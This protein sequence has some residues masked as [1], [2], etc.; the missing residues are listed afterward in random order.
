MP[1]IKKNCYFKKCEKPAHAHGLCAAHAQ[2]IR[3]G[4]TLRPLRDFTLYPE[5]FCSKCEKPFYAKGFCKEHYQLDYRNRKIKAE[6]ERRRQMQKK[7]GW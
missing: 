2:Q 6:W 3:R 5:K 4:Q 1:K 7:R